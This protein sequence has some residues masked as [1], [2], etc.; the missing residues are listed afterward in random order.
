MRRRAF[1]VGAVI[2]VMGLVGAGFAV[3]SSQGGIVRHQHLTFVVKL[4]ND[5]A[6]DLPPSGFSL[7]D[8]FFSQNDLWNFPDLTKRLGRYDS[9]CVVENAD[10]SL[11]R[12]TATV[13][14]RSGTVELAGRFLFTEELKAF[15]L[16]VIGGTGRYGHVVGQATYTF[17]C[18]GCPPVHDID[19]LQLNLI[20]SFESP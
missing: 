4:T 20:P 1:V 19:T 13:Y 9:A 17:S 11:N 6:L 18:E 16:A 8:T 2:L 15:R 12:C 14:L 7:G 5:D 3:A 10:T